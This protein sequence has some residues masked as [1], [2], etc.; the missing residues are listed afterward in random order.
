MAIPKLCHFFVLNFY[1]T[2][3]HFL[4]RI[5]IEYE[6]EKFFQITFAKLFKAVLKI[7]KT[8]P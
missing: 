6:Y 8:I 3:F 5:N 4:L 1:E 2:F 7:F